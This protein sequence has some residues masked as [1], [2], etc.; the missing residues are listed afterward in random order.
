MLLLHIGQI[1]TYARRKGRMNQVAETDMSAND[2]KNECR[3]RRWSGK[4]SLPL[5]HRSKTDGRR[6]SSRDTRKV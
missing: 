5:A 2:G 1:E 4:M 3:W 6:A